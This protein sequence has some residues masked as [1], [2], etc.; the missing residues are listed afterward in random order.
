MKVFTRVLK[1]RHSRSAGEAS[2]GASASTPNS[3]FA[4][5]DN[6]QGA[7]AAIVELSNAIGFA[8]DNLDSEGL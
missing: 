7:S 2:L 3:G 8:L 5:V 1:N 6:S 4:F